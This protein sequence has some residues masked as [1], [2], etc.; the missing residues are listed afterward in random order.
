[1]QRAQELW[2][3][4]NVAA[5]DLL[6]SARWDYRKWEHRHLHTRFNASHLTFLGHTDRVTS[7][8]F[9]PDSKRIAS[10]SW[11]VLGNP[12]E[13]KV[14][15]AQTGQEVHALQGHTDRVTSV[16]F[17]P[18]GTRVIAASAKGEVRAWDAQTGQ[19]I[20]PC[21]DPPPPPQQQALS[22]DGQRLVRIVNGQPVVQPR[23]LHADEYFNR[24]LQD[25]ART[26][27]WHLR[28]TQ[29]ARQANDDFALRFHLRPLLLT[30]FTRWQ[31]HPHD[32]FPYWAW[33]PPLT[34]SQAPAAAPQQAVTLPEAELRHLL[35]ELDRQVQAEPKA[36]EVWAA[37]GWC[38]HLLGDTDD[39]RA[40]LRK[41]SDL[42]PDEPGLWALRG[43]VCL[44]QQR[45]DEAEAV[46]KRLAAWQ[47]I[48]VQVWH[49]C[50]A[51]ACAAEGARVEA[52]WHRQH[53]PDKPGKGDKHHGRIASK[54]R[55][56]C[57]LQ[58]S[59]P[60]GRTRVR[61]P[62]CQRL[63]PL[64]GQGRQQLVVGQPG[65]SLRD[66]QSQERGRRRQPFQTLR[67][68]HLVRRQLLAT[69]QDSQQRLRDGEPLPPPDGLQC[70]G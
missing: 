48:N 52:D 66:S 53:L 40:D 26:H 28:M 38:C 63:A 64:R 41:A 39:A 54:A 13:L 31:D 8:A 1:M 33:R 7:V 58:S 42:H 62:A 3:Q 10:G 23:L 17:S 25:Q 32:A 15:D 57:C 46:H 2:E 47:G 14:W 27:F 44:K 19:P 65:Q 36:W 67:R 49:A 18:D 61:Q 69:C 51:V 4:G 43:T 5:Q 11:D 50:E 37:R 56:T 55:T 12:G 45:L 6:D 16:A 34:R 24:R 68:Q 60:V 22:P 21:T 70:P 35:E 30:N 59:G 29:E 9:S 20:L